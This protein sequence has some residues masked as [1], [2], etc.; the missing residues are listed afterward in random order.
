MAQDMDGQRDRFTVA[1]DVDRQ[2]GSQW[3]RHSAAEPHCNLK[4]LGAQMFHPELNCQASD[5]GYH[6]DSKVP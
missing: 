2:T 3:P 6:L 4:Y 1:Q 5:T